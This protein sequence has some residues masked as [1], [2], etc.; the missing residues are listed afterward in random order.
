MRIPAP[1]GDRSDSTTCRA[2]IR[3]AKLS[4]HSAPAG[5]HSPSGTAPGNLPLPAATPSERTDSL[6]CSLQALAAVPPSDRATLGP[7]TSSIAASGTQRQM[8]RRR[9]SKALP[10]TWI[11]F[12]RTQD[13]YPASASSS[14]IRRAG[15]RHSNLLS[16]RASCSP[17]ESMVSSNTSTS[18]RTLHRT[19]ESSGSPVTPTKA[20]ED[21]TSDNPDAPIQDPVTPVMRLRVALVQ[22]TSV[23]DVNCGTTPGPQVGHDQ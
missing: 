20:N 7:T 2:H 18:R 5:H 1:A 4:P 14:F 15:I 11:R 13:S 17:A 8:R 12:S 21:A 3:P 9:P 22:Q 19:F 6:P 10:I 23:S 16:P